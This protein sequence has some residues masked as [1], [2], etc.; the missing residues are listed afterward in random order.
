MNEQF[1]ETLTQVAPRIFDEM[2]ASLAAFNKDTYKTSFENFLNKYVDLFSLVEKLTEEDLED[3]ELV[4]K[5]GDI[6]AGCVEKK[7]EAISSKSKCEKYMMNVNL[8]MVSYV[9]PGI[10]EVASRRVGKPF[11]DGICKV[12]ST[13][14]KG[15]HIQAA[16]SLD[17][18]GG[19]KR[20]LCYVTTATCTALGLSA[21]CEELRLLK[22]YRDTVL[23]N[24]P[25]GR[26]LVKQYYNIAPTIVKRI[27][28]RADAKAVYQELYQDYISPC[29]LHI[30]K[31]NFEQ[32]KEIYC[33]MVEVL[34]ERYIRTNR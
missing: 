12:W 29:I 21:E 8:F 10:L 17:I 27:D 18:D 7:C 16:S 11:A 4:Q 32:C 24:T 25:D 31:E 14:F 20:K 33:K 28:K 22:D 34:K 9:L 2:D 30:R 5:T 26:E 15:A 23:M 13:H 19:F 3:G 6:L 1:L